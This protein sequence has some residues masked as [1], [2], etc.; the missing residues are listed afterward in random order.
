MV[1]AKKFLRWGAGDHTAGFEKNNARGKKQGFAQIVSDKDYC[2]SEAS[3]ESAE[4]ALKFSARDRVERSERL[5]HKQDGRIGS[6]SASNADTLTLASGE[7]AGAAMS[8][9]ARVEAN[10]VEHFLDA[11]GRSGGVPTLQIGNQRDVLGNREMRK[12]P[13]VLDNVSDAATKWD[14]IPIACRALTDEH[15]TSRGN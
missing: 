9:L 5:I 4:F 6:K 14:E 12:E 10:E 13:G 7:F 15:L 3:G 8:E 11:G 2:F 1:E